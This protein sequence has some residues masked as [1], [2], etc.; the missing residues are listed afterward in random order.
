[1]P[2]NLFLYI[3]ANLILLQLM[4]L[5]IAIL[6]QFINMICIV[7]IATLGVA[8]GSIDDVLHGSPKGKQRIF[9][10]LKYLAVVVFFGIFWLVLPDLALLIFLSASAFHFGQTQLT[11]FNVV[12]K[13]LS[14]CLYFLWGSFVIFSMFALNKELLLEASYSVIFL[15]KLYY[16]IIEKSE[17]YLIVISSIMPI[18]LIGISLK[19]RIPTNLVL[20]EFYLLFLIFCSFLILTPFIAFS[21]FFILIH[22][23][24]AV[25]QEYEFCKSKKIVKNSIQFL[26]LF[27]PLT[28]SSILIVGIFL[29][30]LI[31]FE[32]DNFIPFALIILLSCVTIPHCFVM[33]K[34]YTVRND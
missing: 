26:S 15:P 4:S 17:I 33:D 34:F 22:S 10:I 11:A 16:H 7:G 24:Q 1:M 3:I 2:I 31:Y 29:Y 21:I 5:E 27:L 14:S 25:H 18:F 20:R 32:Y 19:G 28:I 12:S 30:T 9:F 23:T 13:V 8:H 6:E